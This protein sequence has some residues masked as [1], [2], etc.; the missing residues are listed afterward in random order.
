MKRLLGLFALLA[1]IGLSLPLIAQESDATQKSGFLRFIEDRLSTPEHRISISGLDGVL[2]SDV[3]IAQIT[4]SDDKGVWFRI[5]DAKLNWD[6]GALLTGRLQINSLVADSIDFIRKP[7]P[8]KGI[9]AP[10]P[11]AS[12]LE[13]PQLPVA[14]IVNKLSVPD[15]TFRQDVFGLGAKI[16]VDGK[17]ILDGGSLDANLAIVRKDAGGKLN[18]KVKYTKADGQVDLA[19]NI[20]EPPNGVIANL[21]QIEGRPDLSVSLA[22]SGPI[23]AL[24]AKLE[25]LAGGVQALSGQAHIA[26]QGA[27]FDITTDLGGPI[28]TLIA[29]PYQA[30]FGAST[31]IA[32]RARVRDS[33]GFELPAVNLTGGQ[34]S[35]T[36]SADTASDGFLTRLKLEGK[37]AARNGDPVTL[38]V[39][40]QRARI[41]NAAFTIDY[42]QDGKWSA[43]INAESLDTPSLT[44]KTIEFQIG[45]AATNLADPA[46]RH[47]TFNGD[48]LI[49]GLS[50]PD[51]D[52]AKALGPSV[53]IGLA[54]LW[55]AGSPVKIAQARLKGAAFEANLDGDLQ[56]V[57]FTG[58]LS[59]A[60]PN[61]AVFAPLAGRPL[62]GGLT[63]AAKGELQPLTGGFD[64]ALDGTASDLRLGIAPLDGLFAGK[65]KLSGS[66]ARTVSGFSARSFS[67]GNAD[68]EVTANGNFS[69]TDANFGFTL[70]VADIARLNE[71]ATGTLKAA[72]TAKGTKGKIDL[73]FTVALPQG[74]L[75]GRT[76]T[77]G[78]LDFT[79][80]LANN[81]LAGNITGTGNLG[82]HT[83]SLA[84]SLAIDADSSRLSGLDFSAGATRLTG[85]LVRDKAG[86]F[87]GDLKLASNDI[88][89][90]AALFLTDAKGAANATISLSANN[91][92]QAAKVDA[93]LNNVTL[94]SATFG[95]ARATA[96]IADA[97]GVPIIDGTATARD[98]SFADTSIAT[99][100]AK[101]NHS[102]NTTNFLVGAH[103]QTGADIAL[104]G[105]LS[106]L[107]GGLRID[108]TSASLTG[109]GTNVRLANP[110][111]LILS[112]EN[113]TL[114]PLEFAI[115][116]GSATLTGTS[117]KTLALQA[118]LH[119][120]PLS[121]ANLVSP[122]LGLSGTMDGK[123]DITGTRAKPV[124]AFQINAG[125]LGTASLA[126]LGLSSIAISAEG[127]FENNRIALTAA[128]ATGPDGLAASASGTID[129]SG[130]AT[131]ISLTGTY[132][133]ALA[134][135]LLSARGTQLNGAAALD[136]RV[137]G[138]LSDP[139]IS[140][141]ISTS[142]A[143]IVDPLSHLRLQNLTARAS[144]SGRTLHLETFAA[145]LATG[146]ALSA[147]GTVSLDAAAQYPADLTLVLNAARYTDSALF[148]ATASGNLT[149]TGALLRNPLL[150]GR[151]AV[152]R[153]EIGIAGLGA[154]ASGL[155][156]VRHLDIPVPVARTLKRAGLDTTGVKSVPPSDL[157]LDITVSAP[158]RIFVRGRGIDAELGGSVRLTGTASNIQPVGGFTLIRGRMSVLGQRID[159]TTGRVTLIG[160]LNPFVDLTAQTSA[161]ST[162]ITVR[163]N[164]PASNLAVT[165]SSQPQLPQDEVLSLLIFGRGLTD[166]SPLQLVRLAGAAGELAGDGNPSLVDGLRSAAGLADLEVVTDASGNAA[167]KA[168]TYLQDNV[169]VSVQAGATGKSKI[170]IDLDLGNN[171]KARGSAGSAGDTSLGVFYEQDY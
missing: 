79:G 142:G 164:G 98:V 67:I 157:N 150:S 120:I 127:R 55:Q 44:A 114:S 146:G 91:G 104:A 103:L 45:G 162:T 15:V 17:L 41:K 82:G 160:D 113:V 13:I 170:S 158:G 152:E 25:L 140:G 100:S 171:L 111:A 50:S 130:A 117:G 96:T 135:R 29:P 118:I 37:I 48:G 93:D 57:T 83:I 61:L 76:F 154:A 68:A 75:T 59:A 80:T 168:G 22:G 19:L 123:I 156:N 86:L 63:F 47:L 143:E 33:G 155:S 133:F 49:S 139:A 88:S 66:L 31:T 43:S 112:G 136:I 28:S 21:L 165:F 163:V 34:L 126:E 109:N 56:G 149:L 87:S 90:A 24:D 7:M 26:R 115:G 71:N 77:G 101:A 138:K 144:L 78:R 137:T 54:G 2:S 129:S 85:N 105:G 89:I 131:D 9:V 166:L 97:F 167:V 84:S 95:Q 70:R 169:Y 20:A 12:S 116:S 51:P 128:K 58:N 18:A 40:G 1:L 53:G 119:N 121:A 147:S 72:G 27:G 99:L 159:F 81:A 36:A 92:K 102:A 6:Q 153:A 110:S 16:S 4:I 5:S 94:A 125:N 161:N 122:A 107:N 145:S 134:N 148:A 8:A 3:S 46:R 69:S 73:V 65:T 35:V 14:V 132:P 39:S 30:F 38:P 42:G 32:A 74:Q 141:T 52:L 151:M 108:L 10:S 64:L 23:S 60:T 62:S 106:A 124:A 11:E